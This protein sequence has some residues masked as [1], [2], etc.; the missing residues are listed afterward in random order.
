M[1]A[2]SVL[3]QPDKEP[4]EGV[5][6]SSTDFLSNLEGFNQFDHPDTEPV[7][8]QKFPEGL[9]ESYEVPEELDESYEVP[10]ELEDS[11]EVPDDLEDSYEVPD[12]LLTT[13]TPAPSC[14]CQE[15]C[16]PHEEWVEVTE[17]VQECYLSRHKR[18]MWKMWKKNDCDGQKLKVKREAS[19]WKMAKKMWSSPPCPQEIC[20]TV[21][22]V[23]NVLKTEVRCYQDC[24]KCTW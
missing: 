3:G 16:Q 4:V 18:H 19:I 22:K 6:I 15:V 20:R 17:P 24:S 10:E 23:R 13:T 12:E 1:V 8:D 9:E 5:L 11:Y 14:P 7:V 21:L 2:N